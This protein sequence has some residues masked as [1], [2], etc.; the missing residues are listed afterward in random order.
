VI[1]RA[2]ALAL[3]DWAGRPVHR[4]LAGWPV[5]ERFDPPEGPCDVGLTDLSHRPKAI[6]HGRAVPA[7]GVSRPGQAVWNG[8]SLA[9]CLKAGQATVF[10]LSGPMEPAVESDSLTDMTEAWVLL[11]L[12]GPR[13]LDVVQR[14]VTIDLEPR[15]IEGPVFFA[16]SSHGLRIQ[17][18]N[19][20][21]PS[22]GFLLACAR[23]HGQNVFEACLRAGKQFG[24]KITGTQAYYDWLRSA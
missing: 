16:T 12:W 18:A 6:V 8:Q 19:L 23:S 4:E 11:G 5:I 21:R 17:L 15:S 9:G 22:P 20:R 3:P 14:L 10:D 7:L 13:S 1:T 24:L 2:S